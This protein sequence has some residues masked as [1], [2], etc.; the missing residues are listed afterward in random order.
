MSDTY[1]RERAARRARVW[2]VLGGIAAALVL[3]VL[4]TRAL[5]YDACTK[6]F[7]RSPRSIVLTFVEAVGRGDLA[8]AQEC[9]EHHAYYDLEAGCSEICLSR[10][11]GAQYRVID[12]ALDSPYTTPDGRANL[13]ATVSIECTEGGETHP[14]EILLDSV[15]GNVPWKHWAIVRS[16]FGGTVAEAWCK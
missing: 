7:D 12:I 2:W 8:V 13:R 1:Y 14:A 3:I 16:T 5:F 6:S 10:V 9:W 4:V 15:G 11:L